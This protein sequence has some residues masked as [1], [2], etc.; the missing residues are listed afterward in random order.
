MASEKNTTLQDIVADIRTFMYGGMRTLPITLAG[1]MTILGLFTANYAFLFFLIGF[2]LLTPIASHGLNLLFI[3]FG[4]ESLNVQSSDI[5]KIN[6]P[7]DTIKSGKFAT[8]KELIGSSAWI[9]MTSFFIGYVFTN[10]FNLYGIKAETGVSLID[11]KTD[12]IDKIDKEKTNNLKYRVGLSMASVL[13][14][15][16]VAM[17]YRFKTGCENPLSMAS[18]LFAF[19][20]YGWYE[21]LSYAGNNRLSDIFGI[22]NRLILPSAADTGPVAC[23]PI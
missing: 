11:S 5:C 9:A 16:V 19:A 2:L 20:G 21:L 15:A 10:A 13:L 23:V 6:V 17:I 8:N 22:A 14:F 3:K 12:K 7:Y 18:V 4:G 1:T